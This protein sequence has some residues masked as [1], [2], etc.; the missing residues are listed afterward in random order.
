MN[1][2]EIRYFTAQQLEAA[3]SAGDAAAAG[4]YLLLLADYLT[5][6]LA[7]NPEVITAQEGRPLAQAVR[8]CSQ[9]TRRLHVMTEP[10]GETVRAA[11]A[12]AAENL[13]SC[14]AEA[15][16]LLQKLDETESAER[17]LLAAG[18]TLSARRVELESLQKQIAEYK[19]V[20]ESITEEQIEQLR[21]EAE[22]AGKQAESLREELA[23]AQEKLAG[24]QAEYHAAESARLSAEQ[25]E[26]Q[27][28]EAD[29][30]HARAELERL[31]AAYAQ[32]TEQL[33]ALND[34]IT[35]AGETMDELSA[36]TEANGKITRA[37][38][39][40][41]LV[42]DDRTAENS[43][44]VRAKKLNDEAEDITRRYNGLIGAVIGDSQELHARILERQQPQPLGG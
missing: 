24:V 29:I 31:Q 14:R 23:A 11:A 30:P 43:F 13:A 15:E 4:E 5:E 7:A 16:E 25:Q 22:T 21:A 6:Q 40:E 20:Q 35:E 19:N 9:I 32:E 3:E 2:E 10:A 12:R 33:T 39:A 37:I 41:G 38:L 18:E 27:L 1:F 17:E 36:L 42:L 26:R 34:A 28:R 44:Y 8:R